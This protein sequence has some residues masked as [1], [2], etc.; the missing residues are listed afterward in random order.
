M[1]IQSLNRAVGIISLFSPQ[2]PELG[3]SDIAAAKGLNKA[4]AWSLIKTLVENGLLAQ[5]TETR[6]Y[7]LGSLCY[8]LG[9]VFAATLDINR[10]AS[11]PVH[12]LAGRINLTT[13]LGIWDRSSVLVTLVAHARGQE[14]MAHQLG[15]RVPAYC[16]AIGKAALAF[17][18]DDVLENYFEEA[19]LERLTPHT[20]TERHALMEEVVA[21][22]ERGYAVG[23][24]ELVLGRSGIGAPIF[25]RTG[26]L[27]GAISVAGPPGQIL[28]DPFEMLLTDV[29]AT[30][31]EISAIMGYYPLAV[32]GR[33]AG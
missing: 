15:P 6:K 4:T 33:S 3:V 31:A 21:I 25:N 23:R 11:E 10:L 32:P 8:E 28:A 9:M 18:T 29:R 13:R 27:A 5:N 14:T 26:D 19:V 30:A 16:T 20:I 12:R 2:R 22:R 17:L 7:R 1:A 24:E